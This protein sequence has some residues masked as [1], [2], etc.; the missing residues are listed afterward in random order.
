MWWVFTSLCIG[1]VAAQT[2]GRGHGLQGRGSRAPDL[3][4]KYAECLQFGLFY[5]L[6]Q[7]D[8]TGLK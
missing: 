7:R 2:L 8:K 6:S 1:L 4:F 3:G 5:K